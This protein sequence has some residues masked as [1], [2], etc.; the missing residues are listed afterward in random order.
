MTDLTAALLVLTATPTGDGCWHATTGA[1]HNGYRR[2]YL[3]GN[4]QAYAHRVAWEWAHG[5]IPEGRVI[6]HL[7][8]NA[9]EICP[10][11]DT[12]PHRRCI[13]PDHLEAIT[14]SESGR[15][16]RSITVAN[17]AKTECIAGHP[18]DPANTLWLR[19]G[20]R[21]CR[22]CHRRRQA[23]RAA[24]NRAAHPAPDP[25]TSGRLPN[26]PEGRES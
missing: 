17:A 2:V 4:R 11:G 26:P 16:G 10:G 23:D 21:M 13:R 12:C 8:H 15:R 9:D 1:N 25:H 18:F 20:G 22:A 19:G 6:D 14:L 24:R 7:C 3:P 5:P